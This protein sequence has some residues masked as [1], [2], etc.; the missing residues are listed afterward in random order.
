MS[1]C[2]MLASTS[3]TPG[4]ALA[5]QSGPVS[6][7]AHH[8]LDRVCS[9]FLGLQAAGGDRHIGLYM[10]I[11]PILYGPDIAQQPRKLKANEYNSS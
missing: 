6:R 9:A 7:D 5:K 3:L 11:L 2:L 8:E 4:E 1:I 10:P